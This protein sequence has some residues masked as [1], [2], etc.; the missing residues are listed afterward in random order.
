MFER[1][2]QRPAIVAQHRDG[3]WAQDRALYLLHFETEGRAPATLKGTMNLVG[4]GDGS[5]LT[6]E[7]TAA[8]PIPLFGGKIEGVIVEQVTSL[9]KSE[10]AFT[11]TKLAG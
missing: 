2:Y 10:E 9:L 1:I 4:A 11:R 3:P 6:I 7:G 8:V 5:T